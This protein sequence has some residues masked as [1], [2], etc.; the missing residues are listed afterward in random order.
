[1][2]VQNAD[3]GGRSNQNVGGPMAIY[4]KK[5]LH[6]PKSGRARDKGG[7]QE[8]RSPIGSAANDAG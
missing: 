7:P 3:I 4:R 2:K 6:R 8:P 5:S 1:M